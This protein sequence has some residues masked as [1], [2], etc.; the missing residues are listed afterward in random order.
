MMAHHAPQQED[1]SDEPLKYNME[2]ESFFL[3][4][5][6]SW[7]H[8]FDDVSHWEFRSGNNGVFA[9]ASFIFLA[10]QVL[11]LFDLAYEEDLASY[12]C[13]GHSAL[14]TVLISGILVTFIVCLKMMAEERRSIAQ[15][16]VLIRHATENSYYYSIYHLI[17]GA[18]RWRAFK[19]LCMCLFQ[20][21]REYGVIT[22]V[23]VAAIEQLMLF[24]TII[25]YIINSVVVL[26]IV[27]LDELVFICIQKAELEAAHR[28]VAAGRQ[29]RASFDDQFTDAESESGGGPGSVPYIPVAA[30]PLLPHP[31]KQEEILAAGRHSEDLENSSRPSLLTA[32]SGGGAHSQRQ[33]RTVSQGQV[34]GTHRDL[35]QGHDGPSD[36]KEMIAISFNQS[37]YEAY[38]VYD[39]W[40]LRLNYLVMIL[41]LTNGK[42]TGH[43]CSEKSLYRVSEIAMFGLFLIKI[44]LN[45]CVDLQLQLGR[46]KWKNEVRANSLSLLPLVC[47]SLLEHGVPCVAYLALMYN[48]FVVQLKS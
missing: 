43:N 40:S 20:S 33:R 36:I 2:Q 29:P 30:E 5:F 38:K 1:A 45:V 48:V 21:F 22:F 37:E 4:S 14:L 11:V 44:V 23:Y 24:D 18:K 13:Q 12:Q 25:D 7:L 31:T 10:A 35:H 27:E 41:P 16:L 26:L 19:L 46:G 15:R 3:L 32:P 28:T 6:V 9:I 42:I 17:F 47:W 39:Y 34:E 8:N